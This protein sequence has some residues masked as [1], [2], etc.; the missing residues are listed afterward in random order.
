M[1][2]KH[3]WNCGEEVPYIYYNDIDYIP[4]CKKCGCQYP[5]KPKDEAYLSIYQE[6][7]LNNRTDENFNK[8]FD[9]LKNVTYNVIRHKLKSKSSYE[10]MDEMLDNVQWT[11]EKLVKY[12]KEKPDFKINTSFVQYISQLVLYPLY[13]KGDKEKRHKEI[14]IHIPKFKNSDKNS[15]ELTDY[16]SQNTD[17]GIED[18]ENKIDY[19]IN[20]NIIIKKSLDFIKNVAMS[21]YEYENNGFKNCIYMLLLYKFFI[22]GECDDVLVKKIIDSM[23]Y[24]L[25][26]KFEE[27]KELY[28]NIL[29]NYS[30]T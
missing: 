1:K 29:I 12:Y 3:C 25:L 21:I 8:L 22:N 18:M 19:D 10:Q 14:S 4:I 16:I 7:Y 28:K 2:I 13:N 11:L 23:D 27:S 26:C 9:L 6:E 17:N 5:E 30:N 15:K 20:S 24:T